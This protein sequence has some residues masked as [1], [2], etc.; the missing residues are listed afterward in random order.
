MSGIDLAAS[1]LHLCNVIP[2]TDI[3]GQSFFSSAM[4]PAIFAARDRC[5][6]TDDRIRCVRTERYKYIRNLQPNRPYMQFNP[7]KNTN[8]RYGL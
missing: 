6:G 3:D 4:R 2:L 7:T 5:D 8:I 1:A